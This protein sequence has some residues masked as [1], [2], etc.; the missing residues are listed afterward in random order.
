[1]VVLLVSGVSSAPYNNPPRGLYTLEEPRGLGSG[2]KCTLISA[3]V[4]ALLPA[5]CPFMAPK[6]AF[7]A[8][9]KAA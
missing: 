2:I 7:K 5:I 1:M 8:A 9:L 3:M 4:C 6:C